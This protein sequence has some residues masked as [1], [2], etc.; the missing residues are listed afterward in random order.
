[1]I[2]ASERQYE[3]TLESKDKRSAELLADDR[4]MEVT[5]TTAESTDPVGGRQ[6]NRCDKADQLALN[7]PQQPS[8]TPKIDLPSPSPTTDLPSS[9]ADAAMDCSK[10]GK[11]KETSLTPKFY[12]FCRRAFTLRLIPSCKSPWY[13]YIAYERACTLAI[14]RVQKKFE[15]RDKI[16]RQCLFNLG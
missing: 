9:S 1:M 2:I 12:R 15:Q 8:P 4:H 14:V 6:D 16:I 5:S 3:H 13:F 11:T 7:S 10:P